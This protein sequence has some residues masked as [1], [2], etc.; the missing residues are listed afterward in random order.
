MFSFFAV[1]C[2]HGSVRIVNDDADLANQ[3]PEFD[4]VQDDVA[5]GRVEVCLNNTFGT[6]CDFMW[7]NLDA[8]VVCNQL[9]F[10]PYGEEYYTFYTCSF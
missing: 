9:G 8:S 3:L 2:I 10:S 1:A 4:F 7:N 5:R 6:I